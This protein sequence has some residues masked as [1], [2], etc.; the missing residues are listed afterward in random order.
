MTQ[1]LD[2]SFLQ[3]VDKL[4][5]SSGLACPLCKHQQHTLLS[6]DSAFEAH[7]QRAHGDEISKLQQTNPSFDIQVWSDGLKSQAKVKR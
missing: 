2:R 5:Q 7:L 6:D 1:P 4:D 3:H